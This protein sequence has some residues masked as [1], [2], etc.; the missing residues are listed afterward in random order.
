MR[1][2]A[3][4]DLLAIPHDQVWLLENCKYVLVFDDRSVETNFKNLTYNRY[5][6]DLL[7]GY[8]V[9]IPYALSVE[10]Y[11]ENRVY[12]DETHIRLL[13]KAFKHVCRSMGLTVYEDKEVLLK[14]VYAIVNLLLVDYV[15]RVK[16]YTPTIDAWDMVEVVTDLEVIATH[17]A[18][19]PYPASIDTAY[20]KLATYLSNRKDSENMFINAYN[21]KS[22]NQNQANQCLGPR[23][24]V[25]DIDRMVF[26]KPVMSGFIRGMR[27]FYDVIVE[28]RTAAKS[29][30]ASDIHIAE[31]EYKSRLLQLLTMVV[32]DVVPGDCGSTEYM[33]FLVT[34]KNIR[35]I[36]G[37]NYLDETTN[38]IHTIQG[39]EEHLL[40]QVIKIRTALGCRLQDQH[41]VCSCCLGN[42]GLNFKKRSNIGYTFAS[43]MME[44]ASQSILST[45]HLTHSVKD[46]QIDLEE[47]AKM[48]FEVSNNNLLLIKDLEKKLG[49]IQIV[50]SA[51]ELT[52][53]VDYL[54]ANYK[55]ISTDK[56]GQLSQVIVLVRGEKGKVLDHKVILECGDSKAILTGEFLSYIKQE[57]PSFTERG[58]FIVSLRNWDVTSPIFEIPIKEKDL[59]SFV[60]N[61]TSLIEKKSKIN[62]PYDKLVQIFD[63]VNKQ[64]SINLSIIGAIV[65][66]TTAYNRSQDNYSLGRNSPDASTA[67]MTSISRYRSLSLLYSTEKQIGPLFDLDMPTFKTKYRVD[68]PMDIYY[69]CE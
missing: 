7:N 18:V 50:I 25:A 46:N 56:I 51:K 15:E 39:D 54:N 58:D 24:F 61:L 21:S 5:I 11:L 19:E 36:S 65:Y 64:F 48:F 22:I 37:V 47:S 31:S 42:I 38:T 67:D 40:N 59:I 60:R 16:H 13:E 20:N 33:D 12:N 35:Q 2:I 27:D 49:D 3:I 26:R 23:G 62:D 55:H 8:N 68:H 45:K 14:K 52:R 69:T 9:S 17:E 30:S 4:R 28:S 29:L 1:T 53:L 6:L 32:V 63:Y 66:A 34:N 57:K 10:S 43:Y 44:K 41:S